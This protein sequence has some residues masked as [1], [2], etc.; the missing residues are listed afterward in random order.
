M[1]YPRS[2]E[3]MRFHKSQ[4]SLPIKSSPLTSAI[5]PLKQDVLRQ[6]EKLL[7]MPYVEGHPIVLNVTLKLGTE[8]SPYLLQPITTPYCARPLID[9]FQLQS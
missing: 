1:A 3:W 7:N 8:Y 9:S 4:I 5:Q 6:V 2:W